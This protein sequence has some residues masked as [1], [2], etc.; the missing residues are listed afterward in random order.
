MSDRIRIRGGRDFWVGLGLCASSLFALWAASDLTGQSDEGLGPGSAPRLY[1]GLLLVLG[2]AIAAKGLLRDGPPV[3]R[4]IHLR[5]LAIPL[6]ILV[7]GLMIRSGGLVLSSLVSAFIAP[8]AIPGV[9]L[10]QAAF[11]AI[12]ITVII[13]A[14]FGYALNV[15][16]PLW[17]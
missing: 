10:R 1:A 4:R 8:L 13:T 6:A 3:S 7:F 15:E 2:A 12:S 14:I 16:I 5:A 17:P 11:W 9:T